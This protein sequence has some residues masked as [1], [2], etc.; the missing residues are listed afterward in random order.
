MDS[1][2]I[3]IVVSSR[4]VSGPVK[5][6]LQLVR[7]YMESGIPVRILNLVAAENDSASFEQVVKESGLQAERIVRGGRNYLS[8]VMLVIRR[9]RQYDSSFI[10]THSF[11]PSFIGFCAKLLTGIQWVCFLHGTT[12]ENRK[13]RLFHRLESFIQLYADR[14]I[15]VSNRQRRLIPSGSDTHRVKVIHN[16]VDPDRPVGISQPAI[17]PTAALHHQEDT[18][19]VVAVGRLSPEKG[20]DVFVD[21]MVEISSSDPAVHGLIVGDGPLR[22]GIRRQINSLGLDTRVSLIG[23]T[24]TPGDYMIHAKA[25]VLPS[26]SEGIPNVALEAMALGVPVV[27]TSVGGVPEVVINNESGLLVPSDSPVELGNAVSR[28]L[29]DPGLAK[30]LADNGYRR[31][32]EEFSVEVRFRKVVQTYRELSSKSMFSGIDKVMENAEE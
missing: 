21:A 32:C 12:S 11:L 13:V 10:Q 18:K 22:E 7:R 1:G 6:V 17:P 30:R 26:R 15:L 5:G 4:N 14:V 19:Y 28:I 9:I 24:P 27:A 20:M 29:A 2:G 25:I 16:A 3:L 31:V 8:M 23:H